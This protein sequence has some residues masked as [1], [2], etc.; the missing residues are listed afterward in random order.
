MLYSRVED[1]K[2]NKLSFLSGGGEMGM[3]IRSKDWASTPLGSPDTW[4]QS[5]RTVI[6]IILN[7][8]FPMFLFWGSKLICFYNN[9][10][11]PSLGKN[12]KHP[13]ILGTPGEAA[14][15]EIWP[16]IKPLIDQVLNGGEATWSEDQLIPIFRNGR[17]EDVYWT[18]SYSPVSDESGSIGGV[19][20]TCTETTEKVI[21][22]N[23][24]VKAKH[25]LAESE[26]QFRNMVINS[27]VA[28]A[29]LK[30]HD[31]IVEVANKTMLENLWQKEP[32]EVTG[33]KLFD[34]FPEL[35]RQ[36]YEVILK[37][38]LDTG[39]TLKQTEAALELNKA[40]G[41]NKFYIDFQ[42][43]PMYAAD[44][45]LSGIMITAND[46]TEQVTTRVSLEE[47]QQRLRSFV[48]SA[49]F[50]IGVYTGRE[51]RIALVNQSIINV[52]GKGGDVIGK[53]YAEVLPELEDTGIYQQLDAVYT[54]GIPF[55][56]HNQRIDLVVNNRMQ[57]HY[58]NYSFT[59]LLD[60]KGNIYGVMNTAAEVT[61]LVL[62]KQEIEERE[63]KFRLLAD[64]MPDFVWISD[65]E[66][67]MTYFNQSLY[68]YTGLRPDEIKLNGWLQIVHPEEIEEN[69]NLW[70]QSVSTGAGFLF[71]HRFRRFD[72][73]YRWQLS[74]AIPQKDAAGNIQMWVGTSTDIQNMKE[75]DQQKDLF[76]SMASHEL[77]TPV[78][79]IKGYVQIL[80]S[81]YAASE[82]E[83]LKTSL[84]TVDKQIITLTNLISELLDVSKIK[85]GNLVLKRQNFSINQLIEETLKEI[86][87]INPR[88][89]IS[90]IAGPEAFVN[91]DRER[92]AQVLINLLNNA[93]K[94]SPDNREI[95]VKSIV[96]NT[97]AL[98]TVQDSGI[99]IDK[100]DQERIFERFYRVEGKNESTFPGFGIGL[101]IA[102]EIIKRH[103]GKIGVSSEPG[104]GSVFYFSIPVKSI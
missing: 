46:V 4:P 5:L 62:A 84:A 37:E 104:K 101:F 20:V 44:N 103:N 102:S 89:T 12:G 56:A 67:N 74:R 80:R 85:S 38:V 96:E 21:T 60:A 7:S 79:S 2:K 31:H 55:H 10:Y 40:W 47:N 61:D 66:G 45:S 33:K 82:D 68:N 3:L 54:T 39:K 34:I 50:P 76:I 90:F 22:Y 48:E 63:K 75:Q 27:P 70:N 91:A 28:M 53:T 15:P 9:A 86:R 58:F 43:A 16:I 17:I 93:I 1:Q 23:E 69:L 94:Y 81:M 26:K 99:G 95:K 78:T 65:A 98:V 25:S 30:G 59:P 32:A 14:W 29:I 72:G 83:F 92:I 71:E 57:T 13:G 35:K 6:G 88:Y 24:T 87:Q 77:K 11:R 52:W 19:L 51:M 8:K 18:F 100:H 97:N 36:N 42:F 41:T 73:T 64:S 49:P